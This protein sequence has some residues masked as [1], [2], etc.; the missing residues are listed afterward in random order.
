MWHRPVGSNAVG[1]SSRA[2]VATDFFAAY[3]ALVLFIINNDSQYFQWT[4]QPPKIAPSHWGSRPNLI[5]LYGYFGP[6]DSPIQ[7]HLELFI[8]TWPADRH[9]QRHTETT[10]LCI[11]CCVAAK[12]YSSLSFMFVPLVV[13]FLGGPTLRGSERFFKDTNRLRIYIVNKKSAMEI[14]SSRFYTSPILLSQTFLQFVIFDQYAKHSRLAVAPSAGWLMT[15]F[16][17]FE[18]AVR[19]FPKMP[20][21]RSSRPN[22]DLAVVRRNWTA[23]QASKSDQKNNKRQ[24]DRAMFYIGSN[25]VSTM[26][27]NT[28]VWRTNGRVDTRTLD[29]S[30]H[31]AMH[32]SCIGVAR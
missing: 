17:A 12:Q 9:T 3:T 19:Y 28:D 20:E 10:L 29:H 13:Q 14:V 6:S 8:Q 21:L 18:I 30:I 26:W 32:V 24:R 5:G 31:R 1:C 2:D 7:W 22:D 11:D 15:V 23:T 27:Y 16:K 4:G 25:L